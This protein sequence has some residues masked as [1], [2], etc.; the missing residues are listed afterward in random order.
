VEVPAGQHASRVAKDWPSNNPD[1]NSIENL[2]C[3][4]KYNV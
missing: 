4:V 3:I 1:L 2:W